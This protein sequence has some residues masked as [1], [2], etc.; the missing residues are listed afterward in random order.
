VDLGS[1]ALFSLALARGLF[2][3]RRWSTVLGIVFAGTVADID[4]LSVPFGPSAYF[5][6]RYTFTH[7]LLGTLLLII[8]SIFF[9]RYLGR[10]QLPE[11]LAALVLPLALAA[12][13]HVALD[14]LGSE[15]IAL[16]WPFS[17]SRYAAD[18][19]P[20]IDMWILVV[21][22]FGI[23]V[24]ELM[25]L[26]TSE[27]GV[28]DKRPRGRNGA[29]ASL[30]LLIAYVGL[31]VMLHTGVVASLD[32]HSYGGESA[33]RVA[34]FP[35]KI[36]P[37]T[38]H[39]VVETQSLLCQVTV[40]TV[41]GKSFDAESAECVHKPEPS[42][43]LSAAG[44]SDAVRAYVRAEPFPRAMVSKTRDGYEV[45]IRSMRD[46]DEHETRDSIAVRVDLDPRSRVFDEQFIWAEDIRIR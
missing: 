19:L 14:S 16:F 36:S 40:P 20:G 46:V 45:V 30:I 15:G 22:I 32:P 9:V 23:L 17:S 31:R 25:R 35:D 7:S 13:L 8:V 10:K 26:V 38:W 28:K 1:H 12:V 11:P 34:A 39:G 43:A 6:A 33:R 21:L 27:I 44:D 24:P 41:F 37:F 42:P 2:P 29:L 18:S 4:L 3:R 5:A